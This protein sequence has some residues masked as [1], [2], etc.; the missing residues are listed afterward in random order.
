MT[1]WWVCPWDRAW[2]PHPT[3]RSRQWVLR[4]DDRR[5]VRRAL[6]DVRAGWWRQSGPFWWP[7][8]ACPVSRRLLGLSESRSESPRS[9]PSKTIAI[10]KKAFDMS[11]SSLEPRA[12]CRTHRRY[13]CVPP[14]C[15]C[16]QSPTLCSM[17]SPL[18]TAPCSL[19]YYL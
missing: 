2:A 10:A 19:V 5:W 3:S 18:G 6:L 4:G 9:S 16:R 8:P 7:C 11:L 15:S 1:W 17:S 14:T 13:G 12:G